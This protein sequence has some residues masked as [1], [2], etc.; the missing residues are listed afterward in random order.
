M[1]FGVFHNTG[2]RGFSLS[3]SFSPSPS[4]YSK[5]KDDQDTVFPPFLCSL[6]WSN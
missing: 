2:P 1:F 6:S 5:V 3:F 4:P